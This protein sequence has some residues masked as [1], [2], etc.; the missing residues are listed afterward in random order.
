[1][2]SKLTFIGLFLFN[3]CLADSVNP[4]QPMPPTGPTLPID[5]STL[6]LFVGALFFAFYQ[7]SKYTKKESR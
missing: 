7:L 1:M 3:F 6:L 4:P 2:R 5:N